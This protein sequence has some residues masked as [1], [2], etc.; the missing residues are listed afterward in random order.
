MVM[1]LP[2]AEQEIEIVRY[3]HF[4]RHLCPSRHSKTVPM[5]I[6]DGSRMQETSGILKAPLYMA[7]V[8]PLADD[9]GPISRQVYLGLR[10]AIVQGRSRPGDRPPATRDLAE[11]LGISR[12]VVLLAYDQLLSEGFV[13]GRPGSGTYASKVFGENPRA[14]PDSARLRLSRFGNSAAAAASTV[15]FPRRRAA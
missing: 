13:E 15:D 7:L 10:G 12:T 5:K 4:T 14:V 9:A 3:R 8:I 11:Q 6:P 1:T 2:R